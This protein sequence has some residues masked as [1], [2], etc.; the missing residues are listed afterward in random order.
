[1]TQ[2]SNLVSQP[3]KGDSRGNKGGSVSHSQAGSCARLV[4]GEG[5]FMDSPSAVLPEPDLSCGMRSSCLE[6]GLYSLLIHPLRL[7]QGIQELFQVWGWEMLVGEQ[8][9]VPNMCFSSFCLCCSQPFQ[10][11]ETS[12]SA[13][14]E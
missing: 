12:Q 9:T 10:P 6:E 5:R 8:D 3:G 14:P 11:I 7:V 4:S 2:N 1:M 13:V